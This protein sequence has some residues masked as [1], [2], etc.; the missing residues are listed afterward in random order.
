MN[1]ELL[2]DNAQYLTSPQA[3]TIRAYCQ[4]IEEG[5]RKARTFAEARA[6]VESSCLEFDSSC[7]SDIIKENLRIYLTELLKKYW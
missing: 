4:G 1:D 3:E 2:E 5:I 7:E 6:L